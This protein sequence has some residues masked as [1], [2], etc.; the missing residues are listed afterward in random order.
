MHTVHTESNAL[1]PLI[2]FFKSQCLKMNT[3]GMSILGMGVG[4]G[5]GGRICGAP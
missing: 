5:V 1:F 4:V 2:S 3:N